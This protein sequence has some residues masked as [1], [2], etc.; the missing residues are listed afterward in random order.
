MWS[1]RW[2]LSFDKYCNCNWRGLYGNVLFRGSFWRAKFDIFDETHQ[3]ILT[4]Q[5]P[6]LIF[7]GAFCPCDNEFK[8]NFYKT[9]SIDYSK[10]Y[11]NTYLHLFSKKLL[12]SDNQTQIGSIKKIYAGFVTELIST[13]DHFVIN[14]KIKYFF[15]DILIFLK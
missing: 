6:Y 13:A 3:P 14:C 7:D 1:K 12:T 5:G 4:I 8:V 10:K 9:F 2:H 15:L 11:G